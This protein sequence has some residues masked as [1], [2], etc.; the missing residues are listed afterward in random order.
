MKPK[1][2]VTLLLKYSLALVFAFLFTKQQPSLFA[3]NCDPTDQQAYRF[4]SLPILSSSTSDH[5]FELHLPFDAL[6][7]TPGQK[8][9]DDN[10]LEEDL[11]DDLDDDWNPLA[12]N[13]SIKRLF[14]I[15]FVRNRFDQTSFSEQNGP[16]IPFF[17]LYHS[18]KSFIS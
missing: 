14:T 8:G 17:I 16:R 11:D 15:T 2:V 9:A 3:A 6:P 10:E 13:I 1:S 5:K 7:S 18:W 12:A 4:I